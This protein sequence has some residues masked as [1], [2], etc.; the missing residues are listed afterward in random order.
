MRVNI[1]DVP[2]DWWNTDEGHAWR[3][4]AELQGAWAG[5]LEKFQFDCWFTLTYRSPAQSAI[6]AIDRAVKL[7]QKVGKALKIQVATFI[8]AEQHRNGS[9]HCHGLMRLGAMNTEF[10]RAILTVFWKTALDLY[11]RNSFALVKDSNA[12]RVYVSKYLTKQP[13]DH[14]FV[15]VTA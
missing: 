14:R 10:E 6:L 5:F 4:K 7:V 15:N 12:V 1:G 8:V 11:G 9:Y 3:K 2:A 13:A